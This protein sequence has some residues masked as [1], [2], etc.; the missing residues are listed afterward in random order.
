MSTPGRHREQYTTH[1][2]DEAGRICDQI[3]ELVHPDAVL[4]VGSVA[5]GDARQSSDVDLIVVGPSDLGFKERMDMLYSS[6]SF[7][8]ET[9]VFWYT[10]EELSR[11]IQ[12]GNTFIRTALAGARTM[13]GELH[14][15]Q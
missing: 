1:L 10:P 8:H 5:T 14:V 3:V 6:V 9:D 11:M 12:A 7:S 13:Y 2:R 4:L 15:D